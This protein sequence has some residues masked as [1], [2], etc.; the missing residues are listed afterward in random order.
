MAALKAALANQA[1]Y[2]STSFNQAVLSALVDEASALLANSAADQGVVDACVAKIE[3]AL[4]TLVL[5]GDTSAL[6]KLVQQAGQVKASDYTEKSF[7]ELQQWIKKAQAILK[8]ADATAEELAPITAGLEKALA[9][10]VKAPVEKPETPKP[11]PPTTPHPPAPE[12]PSQALPTRW[13]T[14]ASR[15]GQSP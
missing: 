10:L 6:T 3:Q 7:A 8:N 9:S 15:D 14:P 5:K 4:A 13:P 12:N 1:A 2:T 11:T